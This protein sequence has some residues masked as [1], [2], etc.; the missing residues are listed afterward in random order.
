MNNYNVSHNLS[1]FSILVISCDS[2]DDL[3]LPFF[4]L[5][6]KYWPNQSQTYIIV[7]TK[8]VPFE[9]II[10]IN[11]KIPST[12]RSRFKNALKRIDSGYAIV[13]LDDFFIRKAVDKNIFYNSLEFLKNINQASVFYYLDTGPSFKEQFIDNK[14]HS[15]YELA[16]KLAWYKLNLQ[17]PLWKK[18]DLISYVNDF[19]TTWNFEMLGIKYLKIEYDFYY[20]KFN[21]KS[22]INYGFKSTGIGFF[23]GKWINSNVYV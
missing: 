5:P 4:T 2:R 21:S 13:L 9:N 8:T 22:V 20:L 18:D 11:N 23:R 1:N 17:A 10:D 16:I 6:E 3:W 7:E 12:L 15:E 19:D 14:K